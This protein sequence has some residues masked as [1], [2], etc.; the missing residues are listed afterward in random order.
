MNKRPLPVT[1][2]AL[3]YI[4]T[5]A[6]G[7]VSHLNELRSQHS[8]ESDVLWASLVAL[9]AIVAG[10]YLYRGS[11]WARWLALAWIIFH[12]ILSAFNSWS[13]MVVHALLC[14]VIAYVLFRPGTDQY[15]GARTTVS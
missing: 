4:A 11:N 6:G 9:T 1:L 2:V 14:A 8:F 15:F 7:M 12:V 3:L 10:I 5:G 13:E